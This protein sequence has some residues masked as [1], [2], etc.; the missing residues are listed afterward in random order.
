[1]MLDKIYNCRRRHHDYTSGT[2]DCIEKMATA[3]RPVI[4][5]VNNPT[6]HVIDDLSEPDGF[7]MSGAN[8]KS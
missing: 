8:L 1:M 6:A 5:I 7:V 4:C 3:S 2:I